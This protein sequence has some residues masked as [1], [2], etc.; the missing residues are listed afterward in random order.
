MSSAPWKE[1]AGE[2]EGRG[3]RLI[4][5]FLCNENSFSLCVSLVFFI[6]LPGPAPPASPGLKSTARPWQVR[7]APRVAGLGSCRSFVF[8][9]QPEAGFVSLPRLCLRLRLLSH[10]PCYLRSFRS[11]VGRRENKNIACQIRKIHPEKLFYDEL[12]KRKGLI[13]LCRSV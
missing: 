10:L 9:V 8:L 1:T 5:V 4:S 7:L 13:M 6:W 3:G 12:H 11:H 2:D